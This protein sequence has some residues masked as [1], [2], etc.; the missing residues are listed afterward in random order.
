MQRSFRIRIALGV[1]LIGG[2][3]LSLFGIA[4]GWLML[5]QKKG[6]LEADLRHV[7][8]RELAQPQT[9]AHWQYAQESYARGLTAATPETIHT[10]VETSDGG[11]IYR[12]NA[13]SDS[14]SGRWRAT[15]PQPAFPAPQIG[16]LG[17]PGMASGVSSAASGAAQFA[18]LDADGR[19]YLVGSLT[20]P[21][22]RLTIAHDVRRFEA[23]I[24]A[25]RNAFALA[26]PLGLLFLALGAW[27]LSG[28]ALG[29]IGALAARMGA[30]DLGRAPSASPTAP[31]DTEFAEVMRQYDRMAARLQLSYTQTSR[32]SA[33]AAHE[34]KTPLTIMQGKLER[35]LHEAEGHVAGVVDAPLYAELLGETQR[36]NAIVR[37]LLLLSQAD[38][39]GIPLARAP[40]RFDQLV[41]AQLED[42]EMLAPHLRVEAQIT[43][44]LTVQGDA[45][46]LAQAV[47]NLVSN[48]AKYNASNPQGKEPSGVIRVVLQQTE[49]HAGAIT[50]SIENTSI[51]LS[52]ADQIRLFERFFRADS[53]HHRKV[54]G[55]G[56]GLSLARE[57]ARAHGGEL[58]LVRAARQAGDN[59]QF[60]LTLPTL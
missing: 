6:G 42:L 13:W 19:R 9:N 35:A 39:A 17:G 2:L 15:L 12:S 24:T 18:W 45:T 28:R 34:L 3:T 53:A 37:K 7:L 54:D 30:L 33:D 25:I 8:M 21:Q 22:V 36:L 27:L 43:P 48:A 57:I 59:T 50:L 1:A 14:D 4:A 44:N 32:F 29:P 51:A 26:I 10:L 58:A 41:Q 31:M 5:E 38:G 47:Q 40:V 60:V 20:N 56:L 16:M 23:E 46:L 55:T 52:E 49:A 11:V